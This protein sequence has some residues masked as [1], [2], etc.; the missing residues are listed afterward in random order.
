MKGADFSYVGY[1]SFRIH[2]PFA[3]GLLA[4]GCLNEAV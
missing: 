3:C 1:V 4:L 2:P